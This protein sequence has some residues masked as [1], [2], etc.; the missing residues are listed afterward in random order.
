MQLGE[1]LHHRQADAESAAPADRA[2]LALHEELEDPGQDVAR[3]TDA[4]I[5]HTQDAV[6]ALARHADLDGA[7]RRRVFDRVV[8]QVHDDLLQSH[9]IGIDPDLVGVERDAVTA[10][11]ARQRRQAA[12][13][14]LREL[15]RLRIEADLAGGDAVDLEQI[16]HHPRD[17][18]RLAGDH[19]TRVPRGLLRRGRPLED[20]DGVDDRRQRVAELVP[21][22]RHEL[23]LG[24]VGRLGR[25]ARRALARQQRFAIVL[26][27]PSR[28]GKPGDADSDDGERD[29]RCDLVPRRRD[30]AERR[31]E[32]VIERHGADD[33]GD[34]RGAEAGHP[35]HDHDGE[36]EWR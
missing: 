29:D 19:L 3:D 34:V 35:G 1:A 21:Q 10:G 7:A 20:V 15:H 2:R 17:V 27:L 16:F 4:G 28:R 11:A 24:A 5:A 6:T 13:H 30:G 22:H 32:P 8:E 14:G 33:D 18:L 25:G 36:Q 12:A 31:N 23:V 26:G 9:R